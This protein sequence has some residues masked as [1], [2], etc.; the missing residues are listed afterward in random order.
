MW[1]RVRTDLGTDSGPYTVRRKSD[2][3]QSIFIDRQQSSS[4]S[5]Y[6]RQHVSFDV[7]H[8]YYRGWLQYKPVSTLITNIYMLLFF[9]ESAGNHFVNSLPVSKLHARIVRSHIVDHCCTWKCQNGLTVAVLHG[10][11]SVRVRVRIMVRARPGFSITANS[12]SR[13]RDRFWVR[14]S[15]SS[16]MQQWSSVCDHRPTVWLCSLFLVRPIVNNYPVQRR[17]SHFIFQQESRF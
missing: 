6:C 2:Q 1:I 11:F 9:S 17:V 8:C 16:G 14:V 12:V 3:C 10:R 15:K 7:G 13:V 4:T 5:N